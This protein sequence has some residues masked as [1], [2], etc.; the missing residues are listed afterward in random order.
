[1]PEHGGE[2]SDRGWR[3]AIFFFSAAAPRRALRIPLPI[4]TP[5]PL[6][7]SSPPPESTRHS[8]SIFSCAVKRGVIS[9]TGFDRFSENAC[10]RGINAN[11]PAARAYFALS[12][13]RRKRRETD[14][15]GYQFIG[16]RRDA[17]GKFT[18]CAIC[19]ARCKT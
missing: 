5:F 1:M 10:I 2:S 13:F 8:A 4:A 16:S 18:S 7:P 15:L 11:S 9:G 19:F 3:Y 12:R 14:V 17:A 6:P